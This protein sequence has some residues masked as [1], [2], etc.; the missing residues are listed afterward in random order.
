M[1]KTLHSDRVRLE[2]SNWTFSKAFSLFLLELIN[3]FILKQPY[4]ATDSNVEMW[5]ASVACFVYIFRHQVGSPGSLKKKAGA[6]FYRSCPCQQYLENNLV[7]IHCLSGCQPMSNPI[8][9]W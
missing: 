3:C 7:H 9:R 6:Y 4:K 5:D 8:S 2:V 1:Q